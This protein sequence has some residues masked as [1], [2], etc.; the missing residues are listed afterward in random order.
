MSLKIW[1]V[2]FSISLILTGS[3]ALYSQTGADV[4]YDSDTIYN[5]GVDAARLTRADVPFQA[6]IRNYFL[7][8]EFE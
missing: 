4:L 3:C 7:S 2:F 5:N 6:H 8:Q 1:K